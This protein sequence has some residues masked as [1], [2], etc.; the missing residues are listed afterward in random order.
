VSG[1]LSRARSRAAPRRLDRVKGLPLKSHERE[2]AD[3]DLCTLIQERK[4][5]RTS[6]ALCVNLLAECPTLEW[7]VIRELK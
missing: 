7:F 3:S 1:R 4:V 2:V 6:R 5:K